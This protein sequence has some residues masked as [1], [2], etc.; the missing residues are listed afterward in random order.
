M[1]FVRELS[2]GEFYLC[3]SRGEQVLPGKIRK[4]SIRSNFFVRHG[5]NGGGFLQLGKKQVYVPKKLIGKRVMLK[6]VEL[7]KQKNR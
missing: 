4:A 6:L 5:G 7:K 1:V 3:T 2:D